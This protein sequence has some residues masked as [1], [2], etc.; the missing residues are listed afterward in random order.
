MEISPTH[1]EVFRYVEELNSLK[2]GDRAV[3]ELIACGQRAIEPIRQFLLEGK[4][5]AISQPR[6]RAVEALVGLEAKDV[7]IEYLRQKKKITDPEV[8]LGEGAV[9]STAARHLSKWPSEE[10]LQVLLGIVQE[11]CLPGALEALGELKRPESISYLVMALEDDVCRP[12]AEEAL[13]K[14]GA[15]ARPELIHAVLTPRG[16][17]METPSSLRRRGSAAFLLAEIGIS[18]EEWLQL[19][20]LLDETDPA[21]LVAVSKMA[22]KLGRTSDQV[23]AAQRLIEVLEAANWYLRDE[24]VNIL[25]ELFDVAGPLVEESIFRRTALPD[26]K[27]GV[28]DPVL[29]ALLRVKHRV[30]EKH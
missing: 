29:L 26:E 13:R 16:K 12:A 21:V 1:N 10:T 22:S 25:V 7:L 19:R 18:A 28:V 9:E 2:E 27:R 4:P 5:S 15:P 17:D 30:E 20:H 14:I 6:Q 8:R 11:R 23:L 3:A 24:I